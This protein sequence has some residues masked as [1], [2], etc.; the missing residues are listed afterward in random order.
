[1]KTINFKSCQNGFIGYNL[2]QVFEGVIYF[3]T[4]ALIIL[5]FISKICDKYEVSN[6]FK[7]M[8]LPYRKSP[9]IG[10]EMF[11]IFGSIALLILT[12]FV[13]NRIYNILRASLLWARC[14]YTIDRDERGWYIEET[15]YEFLNTE[16]TYKLYFD[17]ITYARHSQGIWDRFFN[18]GDVTVKVV[19][20]VSGDTNYRTVTLLGIPNPK[21][22]KETMIEELPG[23]EGLLLKANIDED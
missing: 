5:H 22:T 14:D 12:G 13:I 23:H 2:T 4:P 15:Y 16:K 8:G 7:L 6:V 21:P 17:R 9:D 3:L 20:F 10:E 1:M 18:V 19:T 11:C